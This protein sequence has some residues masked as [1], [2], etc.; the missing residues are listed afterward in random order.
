MADHS[1]DRREASYIPS[2]KMRW[3][4]YGCD[5]APIGAAKGTVVYAEMCLVQAAEKGRNT[6]GYAVV[7]R[8]FECYWPARA[9]T[10]LYHGLPDP[11]KVFT[12][13]DVFPWR[14]LLDEKEPLAVAKKGKK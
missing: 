5:A 11:L 6:R 9:F 3:R 14:G 10:H 2:G 4:V 13:R 8:P 12:K 1:G 7:L